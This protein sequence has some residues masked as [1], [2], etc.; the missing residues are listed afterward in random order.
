MR[1]STNYCPCCGYKTI[2]GEYEICHIC[3]WENDVTQRDYPDIT[4]ANR[5]T[6]RRAQRNFA[7]FGAAAESLVGTDLI[8]PPGPT[9]ERDSD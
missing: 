3:G 6:L 9:D 1:A 4:G 2:S 8:R 5:V 7:L